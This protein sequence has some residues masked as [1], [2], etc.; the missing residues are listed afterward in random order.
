MQLSK[1]ISVMI[2]KYLQLA[3]TAGY[4]ITIHPL[5]PLAAQWYNSPMTHDIDYDDI[6]VL[7]LGINQT[8]RF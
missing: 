4:S 3:L 6:G 5:H 7:S 1:L 2:R 8:G